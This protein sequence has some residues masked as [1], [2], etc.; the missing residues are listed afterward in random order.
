MN[1]LSI[2]F[3]LLSM[4]VMICFLNIYIYIRIYVYIDLKQLL[5]TFGGIFEL[6]M[7]YTGIMFSGLKE[8]N[9]YPV[10]F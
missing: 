4:E 9:I 1:T 8:F 2:T 5:F 10:Q 7:H 3:F 6:Y